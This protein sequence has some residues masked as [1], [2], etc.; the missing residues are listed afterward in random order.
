METFSGLS[1]SVALKKIILPLLLPLLLAAQDGSLPQRR[2]ELPARRDPALQGQHDRPDQRRDFELWWHGGEASREYLDAVNRLA[3][4]DAERQLQALQ[5]G[6]LPTWVNLGPRSNLTSAS[7]PDIDSGRIRAIVTHPTD[8][9]ILYLGTSGGGVFKCVNADL[10]GAGTWTWTAVTDQLPA[11][12]S[13]GNLPVGALAMSPADPETLFL[14]IGDPFHAEGRG[15]YRTQDGAST[16]T[17]CSGS[18]AMTRCYDILAV[19]AQV[20]LVG[21]N[22]G[23]KRSSDGGATFSPVLLGGN[24]G[25]AVWSLQRFPGGDLVCSREGSPFAGPASIW[26]S[27]DRGAS[28]SQAT[29]DTSVQSLGCGRISLGTSSSDSL[30]WGVA[31]Q[32]NPDPH[33]YNWPL[34]RG[35]LKTADRGRSWTFVAAPSGPN[36]LFRSAAGDGTQ[37]GY[38]QGFA[39]D[40]QNPDRVF[41]GTNLS[42]NRTEDGGLSWFRIADASGY[43]RVYAHADYHATAWSRSGPQTLFLGHDGGLSIFRK[44]ALP[45]GQVPQS[46]SYL[47]ADITFLD[48]RRNLGLASHLVHFVGSTIAAAPA[49]SRARI[50]L[51][52]QDNGTRIRQGSGAALANSD[53]FEDRIGGDGHGTLIHPLNGNLFL[54]SYQFLAINRSVD[55]G[56]NF[57]QATTGLTGLSAAPFLT[58]LVPGYGDPT[59]DT[60][61][62]FTQARIFRSTEFGQSWTGLAMGGVDPAHLIRNVATS[63]TDPNRLAIVT[64]GATGYT[65]SNGGASWTRFGPLPQGADDA[66]WPYNE[67]YLGHAWFDSFDGTTLY[68]ASVARNVGASHLWRS[69]DGGASWT[70]LDRAAGGGG[71]GFP[72]GIPVHVVQNDPAQRGVLYAGTDFGVYRSGDGGLNW[73]RY[74]A[75]LPRVAVRDLYC[76]P[77]GS[78]LR[79]GTYGRGVW[80]I[81]PLPPEGILLSVDPPAFTLPAGG[82]RPL[83]AA[84]NAGS[85]TW[86]ASAGILSPVLGIDTTY[87]ASA[88]A[89][90]ATVTAVSTLDGTVTRAVAVT[91]KTRDHN[92]DGVADILDLALLARAYGDSATVSWADLNGDGRIDDADLLAWLAL[93]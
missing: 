84:L 50:A 61:Y 47:A 10:D 57:S 52:L 16:W 9:R 18:G 45:N 21:G 14:G 78:F 80:E 7:W 3:R 66:P 19:D 40:P 51:G 62:T 87:T 88:S 34:A 93:L 75:A 60:V 13:S 81:V 55:G 89:G 64:A 82:S 76:A 12:S 43:Q 74:G 1:W 69:G 30:A 35:L 79:A 20:V 24:S 17:E 31:Q 25:G 73:Q 39:V 22:D 77:D 23:L 36:T 71:N 42:F 26:F 53:V 37:G 67:R 15:I 58:R 68:V 2:A 59:G 83:H 38:A 86:S 5:P 48:N 92:G 8:P 29:L 44:P 28:W 6:L 72:F 56:R 91:I 49:D 70:A 33:P 65:S 90:S 32:L 27:T 4:E 41:L 63:R 46:G 11:I 85:A 54:G